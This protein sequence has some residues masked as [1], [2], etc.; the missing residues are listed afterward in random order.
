MYI[1]LADGTEFVEN[2]HNFV[3]VDKKIISTLDFNKELDKGKAIKSK[4]EFILNNY[5]RFK[6]PLGWKP[7]KKKGR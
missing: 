2:L 1:K 4:L 7:P 6:T 5:D 3:N